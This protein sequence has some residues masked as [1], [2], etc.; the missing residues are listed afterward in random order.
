MLGNT[1][2]DCGRAEEAKA[3]YKRYTDRFPSSREARYE[4]ALALDA[5][6][7][8]GEAAAQLREV[9]SLIPGL[10]DAY[11]KLGVTSATLGK[12]DDAETYF[13][14]ALAIRPDFPDALYGLASC[15][16]I[17]SEAQTAA[18]IESYL[19]ADKPAE[20]QT[21][22]HFA[23]GKIYD[24]LG[25]YPRAFEHYKKGNDIVDAAA[26]FDAN[27]WAT[28][29]DR[30]ESTFTRRFFS[31]RT[32][33]GSD[34]RQPIFIFGVPRSGTTLVEQIIGS[35][36]QV[37]TAGELDAIPE[38]T[39]NLQGRFGLEASYPECMNELDGK[40][41]RTLAD[42]YL[43]E[44]NARGPA[45]ARVTDKMRGDFVHLGLLALV[46]PKATFI[47]CRRDSLDTCLS[48]YFTRLSPRNGF[49]HNLRNLGLYYRGYR[50]LMAHWAEALPVS[51]LEVGYE[52]LIA[53]QEGV[54]RRVIA[55]CDLEW[56]DRCLSFHETLR[57][58]HTGS[59]WQ[60]R[61]PLYKTAVKRWQ[62]YEAFLGPLRAA[63]EERL[64][65]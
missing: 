9:L 58:V 50:K 54:S 33:F 45:A 57:P 18:K 61:Q 65:R 15:S 39:W 31:D 23:L 43:A 10:L 38:M 60:V 44:V 17:L 25:N 24:D 59:V 37:A 4:L 55:H 7:R 3:P 21:L 64:S 35:H 20:K 51:M 29:L 14:S 47:H 46:F 52:D 28:F 19:A 11:N 1:L 49:A 16:K 26:G 5:T 8:I 36:P 27:V 32:S 53:D 42:A 48:C 30:I 40:A 63:L 13:K 41:I 2:S 12:F 22:L 62:H 56:D 34:S 6:G